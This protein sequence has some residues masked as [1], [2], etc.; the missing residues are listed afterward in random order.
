MTLEFGCYQ[1][2]DRLEPLTFEGSIVPPHILSPI[3]CKCKNRT[4]IREIALVTALGLR[5]TE[6][7]E[8]GVNRDNHA[9]I[10][11]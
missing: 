9:A 1:M 7:C 10:A 4:A 5:C 11:T 3:L 2:E 6:L 8:C